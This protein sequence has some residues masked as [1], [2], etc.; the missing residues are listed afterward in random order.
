MISRRSL[1]L[2]LGEHMSIHI[3]DIKKWIEVM[4][5]S[6]KL[7]EDVYPDRVLKDIPLHGKIVKILNKMEEV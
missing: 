3:R 7:I 1:P 5:E 4:K 6:K 2:K